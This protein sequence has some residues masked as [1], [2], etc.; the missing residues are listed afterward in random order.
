MNGDA[1]LDRLGELMIVGVP[2]TELTAETEATLRRIRPA[3][4][5]LFSENYVDADGAARLTRSLHAL[6]GT[7]DLPALLAVDEEGGVVSRIAHF[8]EVPPSARAVASSGGPPLV[9][10]LAARTARRLLALGFNL[11]FAPCADIHSDPANP[12]IGVRSFGETASQVTA[13]VRAAIEGFQST[14]VIPVAKHFPGHGDTALDSHVALPRVL[15]D[16][17]LLARRD[18]KPFEGAIQIGVP[19]IM[20]GHV[21]VPALDPDPTRTATLSH[22][23]VTGLLR[24]RMRFA[25]VVVTDALEMAGATTL[26]QHG[27][28]AVRAIEAGVDLLLYSKLSPGPEEALSAL[29]EA[30][31]SGRIA[32]ERIA[33]SLDRMRRLRAG[34]AARPAPWS[35]E[36]ARHARDL[37]GAEE[38]TR[39][40]EGAI[41]VLRQGAGGLPLK[42]PVEVLEMNRSENRA[43]LADLLGASGMAAR[44]HAPDPASWPLRISGTALLTVAA[45]SELPPEM[46]EIARAWLRRFPETVTIASLNPQ[47]CDAWPE[48]RTLLTT[49]DNGP[50]ARRAL[51]KLLTAPHPSSVAV[52]RRPRPPQP[53]AS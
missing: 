27:E 2:G 44:E 49:F 7:P 21:L 17:R 37:I 6:L 1:L 51:V 36:L 23:I 4:A 34:N 30:V 16:E 22:A 12:V 24:D 8:W 40:A 13:C 9:R 46:A 43:P 48:V 39:I 50:A 15:A 35:P 18:L 11:D 14:G 25:G 26:G 20:T 32:P 53:P 19:M 42:P 3:G 47:V 33:Q 52:R 29:R 45:R 31:N 28:I 41:R 38:L 5:I 10:D